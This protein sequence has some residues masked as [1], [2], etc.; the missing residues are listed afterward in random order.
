MKNNIEVLTVNKELIKK[1]DL[2]G[3]KIKRRQVLM[4]LKKIPANIYKLIVILLATVGDALSDIVSKVP[5][6]GYA[7][8]FIRSYAENMVAQVASDECFDKIICPLVGLTVDKNNFDYLNGYWEFTHHEGK[9][10]QLSLLIKSIATFVMEHPALVLAG[11]AIVA[12]LIYKLIVSILKS[13]ARLMI[14][15]D[16]SDKQKEVYLLLKN[17]L[18]K[19]R[20]IKRIKTGQILLNDLEI[21]YEIIGELRNYPDMLNNLYNIL[22]RLKQAIDNNNQTELELCR[23]ELEYCV[24]T[25]EFGNDNLLNRKIHLEIEKQPVLVK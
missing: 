18:K 20:K 5:G 8:D 11:G 21:T 7:V 6:I 15:N 17:I 22:Y 13:S 25:F 3:F 19:S 16:S 12:G 2:N 10:F 1:E 4:T 24:Y 23:Q 9:Y 14:Y